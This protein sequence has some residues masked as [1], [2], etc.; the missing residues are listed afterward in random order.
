[1]SRSGWPRGW[2]APRADALSLS[3]WALRFPGTGFWA[4]WALDACNSI[5]QLGTGR[6]IA[7]CWRGGNELSFTAARSAPLAIG[8]GYRRDGRE[9]HAVDG[10]NAVE[11][12]EPTESRD[13]VKEEVQTALVGG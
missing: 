11:V 2:D 9:G 12:G 6:S 10:W 1:M 5:G 8:A 13:T 3:G 4:H 7:W